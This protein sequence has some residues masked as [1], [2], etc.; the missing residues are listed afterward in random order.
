MWY[1]LDFV[2][3]NAFNI[4]KKKKKKKKKKDIL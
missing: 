3:F 2:S 1:I 4:Q